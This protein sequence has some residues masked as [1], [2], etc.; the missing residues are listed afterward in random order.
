MKKLNSLFVVFVFSLAVCTLNAQ[1]AINTDGSDP[2]NSAMLD[3]K[4]TDKGLLIPKLTTSQRITLGAIAAQGLLIYDTDSESFWYHDRSNWV[5]V[6]YGKLWS[7]S[8]TNTFLTNSGD[9]VGIGVSNPGY[10]LDVARAANL[11]SGISS[12]GALYINGDEA[13]WYNDTYFSWGYGGLANYFG[14]K[15]GIGT[16]DPNALLHISGNPV[17][18]RGQMCLTDPSG[19]DPFITFYEGSTYKSYFGYSNGDAV[20]GTVDGS[21]LLIQGFTSAGNV[22]IGT[23]APGY[24]LHV[25]GGLKVGNLSASSARAVNMIRIGD[26]D[27]IRIGEW[28]NDDELSFKASRYNF[29]NGNVGI[30]VTLPASKLDVQGNITVRNSSGTV[31]LELGTGL[32]YA[33]GFDVSDKN[34][35]EP[36]TILSIDPQNPGKL[37]ISD[38]AYDKKVAGIVAGA[39]GLGSGVRLG[40]DEYDYDVALAGRVY[41]NVDATVAAVEPGDLLTTSF[42]P[43]YAMKVDNSRNAHGAILGKAMESLEKGEKGQILVLVT[44]Q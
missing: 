21:D 10:L 40:L 4:S 8:G 3:V 32:D 12:G 30:G 35:I 27:Y 34:V 26:G 36:G 22:G 38:Q 28:E 17:N 44:L 15:V 23:S 42:T 24:K 25:D 33:E 14:D 39:K 20:W 43:G 19:D 18:T 16:T 13:I 29:T 6:S 5:E 11:N 31:V 2:D 9:N 37:M 1:V 7:R 41:C